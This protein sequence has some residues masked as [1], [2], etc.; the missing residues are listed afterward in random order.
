[1]HSI[2]AIAEMDRIKTAEGV[3][4]CV[5]KAIAER[6]GVVAVGLSVHCRQATETVINAGNYVTIAVT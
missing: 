2:A 3:V 5:V 1:M 6:D 4:N